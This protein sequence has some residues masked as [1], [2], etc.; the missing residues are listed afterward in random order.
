MVDRIRDLCEKNGTNF[1]KL[2]QALG[3]ANGSIAKSK[4]EKIQA[5]RVHAM[6]QYF[7]VSMEYILT[8]KEMQHDHGIS[9]DEYEIIRKYREISEESKRGVLA[10]IDSA[11]QCREEK[12]DGQ[13][14][15]LSAG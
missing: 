14:L 2:E 5:V 10:L 3:F 15:R 6:A 11:Y 12:K 13:A 4:E 8:G 1:K 7:G 9:R